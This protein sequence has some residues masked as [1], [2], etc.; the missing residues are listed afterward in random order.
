MDILLHKPGS[1]ISSR[2]ARVSVL[3]DIAL[4][5][6]LLWHF[7]LGIGA[8]LSLHLTSWPGMPTTCF[9]VVTAVVGGELRQI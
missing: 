4:A 9:M 3:L 5:P 2:L 7:G 1:P 6:V 8:D